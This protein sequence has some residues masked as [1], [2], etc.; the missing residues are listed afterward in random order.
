MS[1]PLPTRLIDV[2]VDDTKVYLCLIES[3]PLDLKYLTL[4]H[5]WGIEEF[6]VLTQLNLLK[7]IDHISINTLCKTFREAILTTR[8]LSFRYI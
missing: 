3:P 4:S 5:C 8:R 6:L 7:F 1:G 2:G